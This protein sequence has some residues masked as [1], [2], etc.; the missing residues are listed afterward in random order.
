MKVILSLK[1]K[2][3]LALIADD[4]CDYNDDSGGIDNDGLD[5]HGD[6]QRV[7]SPAFALRLHR[8][9]T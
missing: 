9:Q 5:D 1:K 3:E 8:D 6:D 7:P 4:A 2:M